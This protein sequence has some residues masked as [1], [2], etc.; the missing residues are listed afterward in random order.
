MNKYLEKEFGL[1]GE[2][3]KIIAGDFRGESG[4][5]LEETGYCGYGVVCKIELANGQRI[6]L[7]HSFFIEV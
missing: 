7:D 5:I 4:I 3:V 2:R 1:K 6:E